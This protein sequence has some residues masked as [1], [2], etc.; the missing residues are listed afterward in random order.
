MKRC[1]ACG[2]LARQKEAACPQ[3]GHDLPASL[4]VNVPSN[5]RGGARART[6][7]S[8]P[9]TQVGKA[10]ADVKAYRALKDAVVEAKPVRLA[11]APEAVIDF[12]ST[13][14]V[15]TLRKAKLSLAESSDSGVTY[16]RRYGPWWVIALCF[17]PPVGFLLMLR[18]RSEDRL[19]F[20]VSPRPG[21]TS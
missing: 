19:M 17:L 8:E 16:V 14:L 18:G 4:G 1:P 5:P 15:P 3:C 7:R 20:R 2:Q 11:A 10:R 9:W 21:E 12:L 13:D 6:Q